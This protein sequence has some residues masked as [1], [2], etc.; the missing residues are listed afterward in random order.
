MNAFASRNAHAL[1]SS[2][3]SHQQC[4]TNCNCTPGRHWS[5]K[6]ICDETTHL[7]PGGPSS[8]PQIPE[9]AAGQTTCPAAL[10]SD[11]A[12]ICPDL[13]LG[14]SVMFSLAISLGA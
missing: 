5:R 12:P 6:G 4:S 3:C 7:G 10:I 14:P 8:V 1:S 2:I 11:L 13:P 9:Y